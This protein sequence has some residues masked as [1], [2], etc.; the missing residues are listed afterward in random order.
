VPRNGGGGTLAPK[1][2]GTDGKSYA[3]LTS[4]EENK[5]REKT[6]LRRNCTGIQVKK[7]GISTKPLHGGGE[8]DQVRKNRRKDYQ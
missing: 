1:M 7:G 6:V 3:R 2:R 8:G 5:I 4:R